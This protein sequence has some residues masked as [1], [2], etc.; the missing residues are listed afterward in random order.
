MCPIM[1]DFRIKLRYVE[2]ILTDL[3]DF[4]L[5]RCRARVASLNL[6][7]DITDHR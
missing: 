2:K 1:S 5:K 7:N 3:Y 6:I 4:W